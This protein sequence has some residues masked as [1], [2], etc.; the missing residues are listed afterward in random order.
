MTKQDGSLSDENSSNPPKRKER[1][2]GCDF[3]VLLQKKAKRDN[4]PKMQ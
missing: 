4:E 2:S 3:L 1:C